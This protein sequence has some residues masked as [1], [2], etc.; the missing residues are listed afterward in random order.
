MA[1]VNL[2]EV[3]NN[4]KAQIVKPHI[5]QEAFLFF[6]VV[7]YTFAMLMAT[8]VNFAN[9]VDP[10][11]WITL[12]HFIA[13]FAMEVVE[14]IIFSKFKKPNLWPFIVL[15]YFFGFSMPL[16]YLFLAPCDTLYLFWICLVPVVYFVCF[17]NKKALLPSI[18]LLV[19]FCLF[20][21]H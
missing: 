4:I 8:V 12:G 6:A 21:L 19:I 9:D 11:K 15:T 18:L 10:L 2:K 3:W 13:L 17:G 5:R 16:T 20:F 14:F 7:I 1:R